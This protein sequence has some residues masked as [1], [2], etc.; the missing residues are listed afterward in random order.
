[1]EFVALFSV[2]L[3]QF[4]ID[5]PSNPVGRLLLPQENEVVELGGM[6]AIAIGG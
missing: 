2:V 1:V 3:G 6:V 5:F 4:R